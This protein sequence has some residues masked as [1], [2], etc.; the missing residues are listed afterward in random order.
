MRAVSVILLFALAG[1]P[2]MGS[3]ASSVPTPLGCGPAPTALENP[4]EM[5]R[6]GRRE[7]MVGT[8]PIG[9]GGEIDASA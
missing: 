7:G 1:W 8:D 4:P 2:S 6:V 5:A 9:I 3:A